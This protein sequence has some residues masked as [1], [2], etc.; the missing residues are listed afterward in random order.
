MSFTARDFVVGPEDSLWGSDSPLPGGVDMQLLAG[1]D[2]TEGR[3]ALVRQTIA[4]DEVYRHVHENEDESLYLTEGEITVSVGDKSYDL[5]PGS[6]I[7]LPKGVPH[8][9]KPHTPTFK[10]LSVCSPGTYFQACMEELLA[11]TKAGNELTAEA[12]IEIQGRHGIR[13]VSDDG[14]WYSVDRK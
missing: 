11:F 1:A 4:V 6:F 14:Q 9:I 12:L 5:T 13:N 10:G 3:F 2:H 7:F 8:A